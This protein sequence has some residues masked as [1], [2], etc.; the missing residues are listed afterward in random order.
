MATII[1]PFGLRRAFKLS[2]DVK[3][4]V[5]LAFSGSTGKLKIRPFAFDILVEDPLPSCFVLS[6]ATC[7]MFF[8]VRYQIIVKS[9]KVKIFLWLKIQ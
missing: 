4:N 3:R 1:G 6:S 8:N 2:R 7:L 9:V 5:K